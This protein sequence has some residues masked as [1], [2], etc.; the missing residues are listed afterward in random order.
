MNLFL[1]SVGN[2]SS[3]IHGALVG[4]VQYLYLKGDVIV[5]DADLELLLSN[6]VLFWP[7]RVIFPLCVAE[8]GIRSTGFCG[9]RTL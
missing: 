1:Q 8:I 4:N 2:S 3:A 7:V 9:L 5:A 6:D